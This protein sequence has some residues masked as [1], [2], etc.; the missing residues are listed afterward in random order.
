MPR[1]GYIDAIF[2]KHNFVSINSKIKW[3]MI[4]NVFTIIRGILKSFKDNLKYDLLSKKSI[5]TAIHKIKCVIPVK[6]F[7]WKCPPES[8]FDKTSLKG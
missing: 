1:N 6:S 5:K 3:K 8:T 2:K 4:K 7:H